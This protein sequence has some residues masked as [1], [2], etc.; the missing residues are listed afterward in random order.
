[1][2]YDEGLAERLREVLAEQADLDEKK[3]FGGL[4]FLLNGNLACGVIGDAMIVRVGPD[5]YDTALAQPNTRAF[6]FT[7]KPMKGW[8]VVTPEGVESDAA[9]MMWAQQGLAFAGSLPPK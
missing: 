4:A 9:L 5:G 8:I 1:M 2:A 3:M 7:G 6:D